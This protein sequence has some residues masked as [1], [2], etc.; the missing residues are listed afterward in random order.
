MVFRDVHPDP[1]SL[2]RHALLPWLAV[3]IVL[4]I[5]LRVEVLDESKPSIATLMQQEGGHERLLLSRGRHL[6]GAVGNGLSR[7]AARLPCP[8]LLHPAAIARLSSKVVVL[9]VVVVVV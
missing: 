5:P 3:V 8:L 9:V 4:A 7:R 6:H 2:P 1:F